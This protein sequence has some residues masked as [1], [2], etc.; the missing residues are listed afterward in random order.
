MEYFDFKDG[1]KLSRLGMGN[2]RL[3]MKPNSEEIDYE[4]SQEIIDYAE[5]LKGGY[6]VS[7]PDKRFA[8]LFFENSTRTHYSFMSALMNLGI[9]VL[10]CNVSASSVQKGETLYDTVRTFES[11]GVDGVIIRHSKDGYYKELEGIKIPIFNAGDGASDHPTQSLLDLMTIYEEYG[12][13]E[14]RVKKRWAFHIK[15]QVL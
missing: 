5:R 8:T 1:I 15:R 3:P 9:Q 2:M 6:K 12:R 13:F 7:Y 4:K 10:D 14:G 11:I